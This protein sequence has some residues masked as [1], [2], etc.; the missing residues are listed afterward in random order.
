[1]ISKIINV[2][3]MKLQILN[4]YLKPKLDIALTLLFIAN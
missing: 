4:M 1:M 2:N 3:V